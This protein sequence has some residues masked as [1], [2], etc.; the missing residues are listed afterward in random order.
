MIQLGLRNGRAEEIKVFQ[1]ALLAGENNL[2]PAGQLF[3]WVAFLT[4][5]QFVHL[6]KAPA[7]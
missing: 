2:V 4:R 6:I 3:F 7:E 5:R 1:S